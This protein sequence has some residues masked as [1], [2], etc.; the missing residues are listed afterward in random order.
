MRR[1]VGTH[2]TGALGQNHG[3]CTQFGGHHADVDA[4]CPA[5]GDQHDLAGIDALRH[6]LLAN[7]RDDVVNRDAHGGHGRR[8]R[9]HAQSLGHRSHGGFGFGLLKLEAAAKKVG[10]VQIAQNE[11]GVR[12]GGLGAPA[13]VTHGARF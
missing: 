5:A 11:R 6:G 9:R 8:L 2:R 4:G 12:D 7:G 10:G 13:A 1:S 3:A